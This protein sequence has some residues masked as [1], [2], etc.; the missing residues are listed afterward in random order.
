LRGAALIVSGLLCLWA[1]GGDGGSASGADAGPPPI[2]AAPDARGPL[3]VERPECEG[4]TLTALAGQHPMVISRLAIGSQ[5][6]GFDLDGDGFR[7]NKLAGLAGLAGPSIQQ[8]FDRIDFVV[9]LELADFTAVG[10]DACVKLGFYLGRYKRDRDG[11]GKSV[12]SAGGDCDD[13]DP[14]VHPGAAEVPGNGRDDDCDGLADEGG[15]DAL[16]RDQDGKTTEGGD[17]D[18]TRSEVGGPGAVEICGDGLD[19]DCSG[20]A[21]HPGCNPYD[22]TPDAVAVDPLSIDGTLPRVLFS[23]GAVVAEGDALRLQA[24]PAFFAVSV[25]VTGALALELRITGTQL[26]AEVVSRPGGVGLAGGRLGGVLDATTLDEVRGLALP[27]LGLDP[28]DSLLD[29]IFAS[30]LGT[31]LAL[32]RHPSGCLSPDIDVDGDGHEAFCD[33]DDTDGKFRVDLCIDGDGTEV[34]DADGVECTRARTPDGAL[35]FVDGVSV[36][37]TFEAVAA[38]RLEPAP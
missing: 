29:V 1:C 37:L 4:E 2:D 14:T 11:D 9:P 26:A 30:F 7:D 16:D 28:N 34:R 24:G 27:D 17:C 21:D 8:A 3:F 5:T 25:P 35:R 18:D 10:Q 32:P 13:L 20:V 19:N 23:S 12:A 36:A 22:D 33:S 31:A 15:P 38:A 6:D